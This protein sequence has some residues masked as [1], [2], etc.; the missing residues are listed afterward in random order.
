MG[1]P[2]HSF[3]HSLIHSKVGEYILDTSLR[4]ANKS[5]PALVFMDLSVR[6]PKRSG[7]S[8][9]D[10]IEAEA[11]VSFVETPCD[12]GVKNPCSG[13]ILEPSDFS[14]SVHPLCDFGQDFKMSL[15]FSIPI[16]KWKVRIA[17]PLKRVG[18]K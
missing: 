18:S 12:L 3:T 9:S 11:R 13:A 1:R 2:T 10:P 4:V 5:V 17:L 15:G 8:F 16:C 6:L 14:S 7:F